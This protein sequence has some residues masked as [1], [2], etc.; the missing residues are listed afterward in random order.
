MECTGICQNGERCK[1]I[2]NLR[3]FQHKGE[4]CS[5]CMENI[6]PSNTRVLDCSHSFHKR[7][8]ERWKR[9]NRTC[10]MCRV[11]FDIPTYRI[12]VNIQCIHDGQVSVHTYDTTNITTLIQSFGLDEHLME[13]SIADISFDIE[14]NENIQEVLR[15][16]G[17]SSFRFP[18][19]NAITST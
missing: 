6:T 19:S 4:Q 16:L 18:G 1:R 11:P 7:C 10:P 14:H 13:R 2:G 8:I 17:V 9:T 15:S 3:C 5:I 12:N